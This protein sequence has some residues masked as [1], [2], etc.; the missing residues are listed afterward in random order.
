MDEQLTSNL[1]SFG[2]ESF[3]TKSPISILFALLF[4]LWV[5]IEMLNMLNGKWWRAGDLRDGRDQGSYWLL[6][7]LTFLSFTL[8]LATRGLGWGVAAGWIQYV[9]LVFMAAGIAFRQWAIRVLGRHFSVVVAIETDHRL[10][11]RPPYHRLRHPAYTGALV[12]LLGFHLAL[13]SWAA[14]L[15]T[16]VTILPAF[17]YRIRLE[18]QALLATFGDEYQAYIRRSWRLFP[19]F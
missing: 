10:V 3:R 13:G 9:G 18:E 1:Q 15:L 17:L 14:G 6:M 8:G 11:T 16:A 5:A 7:A 12:G 4:S 19:G 2:L